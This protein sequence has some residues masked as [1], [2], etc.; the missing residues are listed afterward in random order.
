MLPLFELEKVNLA[1]ENNLEVNK[2]LGNN[3]V[4]FLIGILLII[5]L[6]LYTLMLAKKGKW[7]RIRNLLLV[8]I[9][10]LI[11]IFFTIVA[12]KMLFSTL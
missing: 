4:A 7:V 12:F 8:P 10:P 6:S 5:F 1:V 11:I 9:I 2:L 3:D